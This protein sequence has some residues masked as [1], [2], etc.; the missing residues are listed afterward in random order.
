[1]IWKGL[2]YHRTIKGKLFTASKE[3]G[4]ASENYA[5]K[6][7]DAMFCSKRTIMQFKFKATVEVEIEQTSGSS[8][9]TIKASTLFMNATEN[10][11]MERYFDDNGDLNQDG[12]EIMTMILTTGLTSNIH[13]AHAKGLKDSAQHLRQVIALLEEGFVQQ[14]EVEL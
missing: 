4:T 10:I 2:L 3:S 11:D 5:R 7:I 14:G 6:P 1:M 13:D 12:V 9:S 8:K